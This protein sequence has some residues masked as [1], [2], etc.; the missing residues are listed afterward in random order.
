ME[1]AERLDR[2]W[3]ALID[4]ALFLPLVIG[5]AIFA[6]ALKNSTASLVAVVAVSV[7]LTLVLIGYQVWLLTTLGQTIGKKTMGVRIVL[8]ADDSNGGFVVNVLLRGVLTLVLSA[9]PVAGP[10]FALADVLFIFKEDRR[11]LHDL[12]AGT[13]VVK[14]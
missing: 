3:A 13:R 5:A 8:I 7:L 10:I 6:P 2:F 4:R 14:A 11:C 12:I 9:I 1:P